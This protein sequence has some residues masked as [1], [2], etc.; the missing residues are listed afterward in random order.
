M[1]SA[2][3]SAASAGQTDD[4]DP[5]GQWQACEGLGGIRIQM[6]DPDKAAMYYKDALR[7]LCKCQDVSGSVQERLVSELS[8]ALQQKLLLQQRGAASQ[9]TVPERHHNRRTTAV[10]TDVQQWRREMPNGENAPPDGK[11]HSQTTTSSETHLQQE[12][13]QADHHSALPEANR[14]LNNT[15][16]KAEVTQQIL[17]SESSGSRAHGDVSAESVKPRPVQMNGTHPLVRSTVAPPLTQPDSNEATPLA[18]R[19]KSRFCTVM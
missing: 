3:P 15:Y 5:S 18:R 13:E 6:R 11:Q 1:T 12:Q 8:E 14:N 9:R 7:L 2:S 17:P 10:R 4:N 16:N 19:L